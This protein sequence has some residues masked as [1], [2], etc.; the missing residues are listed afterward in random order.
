M[1][2]Q[3][4]YSAVLPDSY[5]E[6]TIYVW[7]ET[8]DKFGHVALQTKG[9]RM[10]NSPEGIYASFYPI[11]HIA[12]LNRKGQSAKCRSFDWDM[13]HYRRV[14]IEPYV[15][16]IH[17][18]DI[19][20]IELSFL[21]FLEKNYNFSLLGSSIFKN[22]DTQNCAGL[23]LY[24][25]EK[26]GIS[27]IVPSHR[28]KLSSFSSSGLFGVYIQT[29][30]GRFPLFLARI[31]ITGLSLMIGC[32][33]LCKKNSENTPLF[34]NKLYLLKVFSVLTL[35]GSFIGFRSS[36]IDKDVCHYN[37]VYST[38]IGGVSGFVFGGG[39][40]ILG[41]YLLTRYK[42]SPNIEKHKYVA[43]TFLLLTFFYMGLSVFGE[44]SFL[45]RNFA[46][47]VGVFI[48]TPKGRG[49]IVTPEGIKKL[50]EEANQLENTTPKTM[51]SNE[52]YTIFTM[53]NA[54]I[55]V[56]TIAIATT[57]LYYSPW[58]T[59]IGRSMAC[60]L[61]RV[62]IFRTV[63]IIQNN[64]ENIVQNNRVFSP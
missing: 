12:L 30:F 6:V 34:P 35:T 43:P 33:L 57:A 56:G 59:K 1:F 58:S 19:E 23:T 13:S 42:F 8:A 29:N 46:E 54:L 24:L 28:E 53:K 37:P 47:M 31:G 49:I 22:I 26:G 38:I 27:E 45:T 2:L 18:L 14:G 3:T 15:L 21:E 36:K 50:V 32:F 11:G 16:K 4:D 40:F 51:D 55:G 60:M 44:R 25:L 7:L 62:G 5:S 17:G 52:F 61:S 41:R 48:D 39:F 9:A 10:P 64:T 63:E 20:G